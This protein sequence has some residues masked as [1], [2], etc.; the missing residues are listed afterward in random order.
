MKIDIDQTTST[1]TPKWTL[2]NKERFSTKPKSAYLKRLNVPGPGMYTLQTYIGE[3]P[4]YTF[5]KQKDNHSDADDEYISKK[6]KGYPSPTTYFKKCSYSPSGP[7]ISMSKLKRPEIENDK[8]RISTPGPTTYNP[9]KTFLSTWTTFPIWNWHNPLKVKSK[10]NLSKNNISPG[11]G[12]YNYPKEI[13]L[14]PKYSFAQRLKK[15]KKDE[16]PGPGSYNINV[17]VFNGPQ[18]TMRAKEKEKVITEKK[19]SMQELKA[20]KMRN[21][22]D[23]RGFSFPKAKYIKKIKF[24]VPGPGHYRIPTSFDY[25]SNLTREKGVFDP[26][27]RY[28]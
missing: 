20:M 11:P 7:F 8:F 18:Y 21:E 9:D 13:G 6:T 26:Q 12:E 2:Y 10:S 28:V 17:V 19:L 24:I 14:G 4:K 22:N 3:G 15:R 27:Y 5:P 25:I 16:T 23:S 1:I